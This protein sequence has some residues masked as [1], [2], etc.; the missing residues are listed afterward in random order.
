M[1]SQTY[2]P[3]QL[4]RI[5]RCVDQTRPD[6]CALIVC[7]ADA[8]QFRHELVAGCET[9]RGQSEYTDQGDTTTLHAPFP[10]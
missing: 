1:D 6:L 7:P 4:A 3:P 2:D 5:M 8:A 9:E 10:L